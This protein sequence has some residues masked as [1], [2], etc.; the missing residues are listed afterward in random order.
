MARIS[1]DPWMQRVTPTAMADAATVLMNSGTVR[2]YSHPAVGVGF[3]SQDA[4]R[5]FRTP[6]EHCPYGE[7]L[8][9]TGGYQKRIRRRAVSVRR[10][11]SDA[12]V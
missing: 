4:V 1:Y 2:G 7:R 3:R 10:R 8:R 5:T 11:Y 6:S 9:H 12:R